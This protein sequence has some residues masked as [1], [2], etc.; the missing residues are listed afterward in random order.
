MDN[1]AATTDYN[2]IKI[3]FCSDNYYI[4]IMYAAFICTTAFTEIH[5]SSTSCAIGQ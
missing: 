5:T 3:I 2:N 4:I 1:M